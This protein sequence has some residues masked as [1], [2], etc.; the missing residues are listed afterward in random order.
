[1]YANETPRITY[2]I[3]AA[4]IKNEHALKVVKI[5][6]K[7]RYLSKVCSTLYGSVV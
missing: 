3:C 2:N 4:V 7:N 5:K 1:M 6:L